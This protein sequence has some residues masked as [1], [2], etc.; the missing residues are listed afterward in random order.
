VLV[1]GAGCQ[2]DVAVDV[3]VNEDGS[4]S[5]TAGVGLDDDA[6][7]RVG[8]LDRQLRVDD[9]AAAG[10]AV[11]API[12]EGDLTWVRATKNFASPDE[13]GVVLSELTGSAGPFREFAVRVDDGMFGR[14]YEVAGTVDLREGPAAFGDEE[15]SAALGGDPFGGTLE[16]I[17]REE[18]QPVAE[19]V[20]FRVTVQLPGA[21]PK[22]F[23]PGFAD[24]D[25]TAVEASSST[26]NAWST[27]AIWLVIGLVVVV[28]IVVLRQ[29][30]RRVNR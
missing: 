25:A 3:R 17:E 26:R 24:A 6:L 4:G 12:R 8:N 30:F 29:G 5:V 1:V 2:L 27:V 18:G 11:T 23:T 20:D 19:M 13:A 16:V 14:D 22:V 7:G 21:E 15:L 10:W 28:G 9:L